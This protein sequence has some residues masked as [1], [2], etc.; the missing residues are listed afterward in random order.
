M[1]D[2]E[3]RGCGAYGNN[4]ANAY[5]TACSGYYYDYCPDDVFIQI[6]CQ[7]K[8]ELIKVLTEA[9]DNGVII[10]RL[11]NIGRD[12]IAVS[13]DGTVAYIRLN[14]LVAVIPVD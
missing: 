5:Q 7:L 2:E 10:G 4:I 13:C 9:D 14:S 12:F 3:K 6:L 11:V 8:G 1:S